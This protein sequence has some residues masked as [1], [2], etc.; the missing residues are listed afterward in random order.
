[1]SFPIAILA[2]GLAT[3]L[4]PIT[5][6]VPKSLIKIAGRYFIEWQLMYLR[7]QG[8]KRVILCTGYLSEKI[9]QVIGNGA[10][11]KLDVCYSRDAPTLLGTGG[12]LQKALPLLGDKFYVMYGDSFLPINFFSVATAFK[13]AN[14]KALMTLI[15]NEN[16]WDISNVLYEDGM[17]NRYSKIPSENM[18]YIDYGLSVLTADVFKKMQFGESFDLA[19]LFSKL[20]LNGDLSGYEVFNRF[21]EIGSIDGI[22]DANKYFLK[23][24]FFK[25]S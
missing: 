6:T 9:E 21:Y 7:S 8:I 11:Y 18:K 5:E 2:G 22:N 23:S 4:R 10:R 13:N 24:K 25:E 15:Y 16:R 20:A 1:M 14:N 17:V 12:A 3:R 19:E